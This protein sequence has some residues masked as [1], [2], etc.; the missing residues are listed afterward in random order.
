MTHPAFQFARLLDPSPEALYAVE[1]Y[2]D[3]P[4]GAPKPKPDPLS[5][6]FPN[7]LLDDLAALIP[8]LDELN[9]AG[10]G[11]FIAVNQFDGQRSKSNLTRVRGV[12]ADFDGVPEEV[13]AAVRG[14]LQPTIEVQ[15]SDTGNVHFYWLLG[16]GEE[17]DAETAEAIHRHLV[18]LGSDKAA[19]DV[20]R[21]LRLPG[22]RHM[23]YR[24][25]KPE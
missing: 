13:L 3:V 19:V 24:N 21:L 16:E 11:V 15:S 8:K 2:T 1:T 6:R 9:K 23:K 14:R 4:S 20:S 12:H 10:A 5:N 18:E 22:F 25:G 17:L 7:L